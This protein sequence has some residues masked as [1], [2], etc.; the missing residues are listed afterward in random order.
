MARSAYISPLFFGR[1]ATWC[2][3]RHYIFSAARN[4]ALRAREFVRTSESEGLTAFFVRML[5]RGRRVAG[6]RNF[7]TL[8]SDVAAAFFNVSFTIRSSRE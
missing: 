8:V 2:R 4:F 7:E 1:F 5:I 6:G 3:F